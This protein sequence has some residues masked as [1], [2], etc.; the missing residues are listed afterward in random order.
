MTTGRINQNATTTNPNAATERANAR[1]NATSERT[2]IQRPRFKVIDF[3]LRSF[4]GPNDE[5]HRLARD[6]LG[7]DRPTNRARRATGHERPHRT[8]T[9]SALFQL[10]ND[11]RFETSAPF[12]RPVKLYT[13]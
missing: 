3:F 6:R 1:A 12:T 4:S 11:A 8:P 2:A 13:I 5:A 10:L 7:L 9:L